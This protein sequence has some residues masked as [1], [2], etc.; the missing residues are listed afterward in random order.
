M[1]LSMLLLLSALI[2]FIHM[3][4]FYAISLIK[5]DSS[6]VDIGW[7][8]GFIFVA[9]ISFIIGGNLF[10]KQIIITSLVFLWGMR[11]AI[12]IFFRNKGKAEDWRYKKWRDDWGKNFAIRAYFQIFMLQGLFMFIISVPIVLVNSNEIETF[13]LFDIVG[14]LIWIIGFIFEALGDYQ[15]SQFKK[16]PDN[17]G[18]IMKKGVWK[19]TRHPNYF[20]EVTMWWGIFII[21]LPLTNGIFTIISPILITFLLLKV[22]GIPL[23]EKKYK[24]NKEYQE[25][26][27]MTNAFFPFFPKSKD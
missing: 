2:I 16:D 26:K 13:K 4:I 20:G 19:Y 6:I 1:L 24:D 17:K 23:L 7:G 15:L 21:A 12:Y 3:T 11:L 18:K 14:S 22:S 10:P 8:L 9:I 27:K 5:K 25:Y